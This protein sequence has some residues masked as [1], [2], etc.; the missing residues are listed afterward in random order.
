MISHEEKLYWKFHL[1]PKMFGLG[2]ALNCLHVRAKNGWE[3]L[4]SLQPAS[5]AFRSF[6][7]HVDYS[8]CKQVVTEIN[9]MTL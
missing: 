3:C 8:A 6:F 4:L 7:T 2:S 9:V 5:T 1:P